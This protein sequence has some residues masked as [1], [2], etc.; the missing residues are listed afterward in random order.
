MYGLKEFTAHVA[1]AKSGNSKELRL[2]ME[3]ATQLVL[4]ISQQ[5]AE[6]QQQAD[7][8][9][10]ISQMEDLKRQ[11]Q[12]LKLSTASAPQTYTADGGGFK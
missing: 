9:V 1:S 8:S 5:L 2:T 11:I 7:L 10:L 12:V 6:S 3:Q 4:D